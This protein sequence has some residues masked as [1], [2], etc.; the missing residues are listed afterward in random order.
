MSSDVQQEYNEYNECTW[1][2]LCTRT[3][4]AHVLHVQTPDLKC[5]HA[6]PVPS[7]SGSSS[8]SSPTAITDRRA[9]AGDGLLHAP[10]RN[11]DTHLTVGLPLLDSA[12][13]GC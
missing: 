12:A 13:L 11:N 1:C 10:L 4:G 9:E 6:P 2:T 5:D 7:M 3:T 8:T